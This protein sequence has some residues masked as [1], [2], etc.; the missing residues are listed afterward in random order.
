M[1]V[2]SESA[3]TLKKRIRSG[4]TILG[5][6]LPMTIDRDG[7]K[8]AVEQGPYDFVWVDGQHAPYNE[9]RL[10]SFCDM[11]AEIGV[12]VQFR[13]KHTL[14]T[15]LVGNYLDLGPSGIEVPQVESMATADEAIANFYY[16]P[17]GMR[18]WGGSSRLS[19]GEIGDR[20]DYAQWWGETGVLWLQI[21]SIESATNAR[22]LAKPGV[23]CLDF[24]PMDLTFNLES[25]PK[26]PFKTVDDC[27]RHVAEQLQDTGTAACFRNGSPDTR[28]KYMD[29]GVTVLLEQPGS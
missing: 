29:M 11:A 24:G 12:H 7:L 10:V 20:H 26:H 22:Q 17:F 14:H 15:Y 28:Q 5:I 18:S 9:D 6:S 1:P 16:P 19:P 4:E 23:D 13:I 8:S 27:V 2:I 21:E 3:S 25:H